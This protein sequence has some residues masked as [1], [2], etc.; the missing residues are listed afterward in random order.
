MGSLPERTLRSGP[1]LGRHSGG[2]SGLK[3]PGVRAGRA[4][5]ISWLRYFHDYE[6]HDPRD[7]RPAY[8]LPRPQDGA[9]GGGRRAACA[10]RAA[11]SWASS[12]RAAAAS[13]PWRSRSSTWCRTRATSRPGAI[14]FAGQN[15]LEMNSSELRDLRGQQI[16]MIFQDPIAGLNPVLAD[17]RPGRGD[18]HGPHARCHKSD[19]SDRMAIDL[20]AQHGPGRP[21]AHRRALPL[22]ALRRHGPARHDRHRHGAAAR[23]PHRRRAHLGPR[24]DGAGADPRGAAPPARPRRRHPADHA[25]HGRHRPDGGPRGRHVRR[26]PGRGGHAGGAVQAPASPLHAGPCWNRCRTCTRRSGACARYRA[27][28]RT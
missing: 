10:R 23:R 25:R 1:A 3:T 9:Q 19:A 18:H 27:G 7:R 24:H 8:L 28:R 4:A 14:I 2:D 16:S 22:P 20:L 13:P 12:A 26:P 11:R 15:V 21:G 17:R 6:R 5:L